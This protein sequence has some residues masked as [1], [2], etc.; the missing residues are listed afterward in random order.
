[1][2]ETAKSKR[3]SFS[4]VRKLELGIRSGETTGLIQSAGAHFRD[5]LAKEKGK[6]ERTHLS[7][8]QFCI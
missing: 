4:H 2:E 5:W 1:M 3:P 8:L 6:A 7:R